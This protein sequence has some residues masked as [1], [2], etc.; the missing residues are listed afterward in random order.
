MNVLNI[1]ST[2]SVKPSS[3]YRKDLP[4]SISVAY[5]DI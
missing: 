2:R 1:I 3:K 4:L 5:K